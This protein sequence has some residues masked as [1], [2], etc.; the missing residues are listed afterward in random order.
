MAAASMLPK[1][2]RAQ[3]TDAVRRV[4]ILVGEAI[5]DD[6]YYEGRIAGLREGLRDLGWIE[7]RN[8]K[9]DIH[10]TPPNETDI[11]KHVGELLAARPDVVVTSGGTTTRPVLKATSTV[12]IVFIG[13]IDPVGSGLVES[14]AH[15]G[16]N[17]TGF[18]QFD[19]SL[20]GKWL[21]ILKQVAPSTVRAGIIRDAA[22]T[23][24]IGQF[25]VI[26]SVSTSLGIDVVPI[27][28]LDGRSIENGIDKISRSQG[29][30]L[31]VTSNATVTAHRE[32][33]IK[34][35]TRYGLPA[36]FPNRTWV[37]RGG[38]IS[39]GPDLIATAKLAASY[40]DR[41]L[42]GARPADLP[43][44]NPTRYELIINTKAAIGLGLTL[45]PAVLAR[46]DE[47]IE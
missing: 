32:L 24:G 12:P 8:L 26:Q 10:R 16:G 19:Y 20:S 21:E 23:A 9:L 5:E 4:A 29:G 6:P 45:P 11:H 28:P 15:P 33:I 30:G 42:K 13:A 37:D 2:I 34:L 47:V 25:A 31:V 44:Q 18:S 17:V 27:D 40:V 1:T 14:L 43:V 3:Q 46:A 39:Y 38:L 7:G 36:T 41:I 22:L 35:A